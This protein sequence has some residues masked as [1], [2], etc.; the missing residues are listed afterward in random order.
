MHI[1]VP[2]PRFLMLDT[3]SVSVLAMTDMSQGHTSEPSMEFQK[4]PEI[5]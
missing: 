2:E 3:G 1:I 4:N 5:C